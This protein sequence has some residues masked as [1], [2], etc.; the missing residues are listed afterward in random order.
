M[1][2]RQSVIMTTNE[3]EALLDSL[4]KQIKE[5]E[6]AIVAA[7]AALAMKQRVLERLIHDRRQLDAETNDPKVAN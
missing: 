4:D 2:R 5:Y 7:E 6:K 1:A 3:R